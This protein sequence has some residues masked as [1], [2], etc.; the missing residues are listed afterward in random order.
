MPELELAEKDA[1][2]GWF[3]PTSDR[4]Q[5]SANLSIDYVDID[6]NETSRD[7]DV[8]YVSYWGEELVINAYCRLRHANRTFRASRID[9]C[10]DRDTGEY[11]EDLSSELLTRYR[12]SE[13]G[14]LDAFFSANQDV[15]K[16]LMYVAKADGRFTRKERAIVAGTVRAF[17]KDKRLTD[18]SILKQFETVTPPSIGAFKLA[19]GRLSNRSL[20]DRKVLLRSVELMVSSDVTKF[21]AERL[22][23]SYVAKRFDLQSDVRN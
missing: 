22:A 5:V 12:K 21:E 7:V 16:V 8:R 9:S 20:F 2:D 4:M 6:G 10:V 23:V 11:I 19:V 17:T 15:L 18:K 3:P 1:W 13:T 14:V